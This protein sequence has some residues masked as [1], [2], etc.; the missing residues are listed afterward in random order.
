MIT[1]RGSGAGSLT[2]NGHTVAISE[3]GTSVTLNTEILRAYNGL[4]R[5]DQTITGKIEQ[6]RLQ[7]GANTVSFTGGVTSV[8]IIPRWWM[9]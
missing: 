8:E 7:P 4:T 5:R 9:I 3:I 6:L 2:V 1:V